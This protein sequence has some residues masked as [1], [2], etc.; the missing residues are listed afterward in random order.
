MPSQHVARE[1][2]N[3]H[4]IA[5]VGVSRN[6][7]DISRSVYKKLVKTGH[8]VYAVNPNAESTDS[9]PFY[10]SVRDLPRPVDGALIMVPSTASAAVVQDC[11][12]AG[13]RRIWLYGTGFQGG[14]VSPEAVALARAAGMVLVDGAC[15]FMFV[16]FLP[17]RIHR[18]CAHLDP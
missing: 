7:K 1:F 10:P 11:Q 14:S 9:M 6:P 15:P 5:V 18:L 17:C 2:L 16:G 3:Q 4:R 12:S 8:E 13:V